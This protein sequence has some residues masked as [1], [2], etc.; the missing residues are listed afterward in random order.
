[1][2]CVSV[3]LWIVAAQVV[4][5]LQLLFWQSARWLLLG[6]ICLLN[7]HQCLT[8]RIQILRS[9]SSFLK[10][11]FKL[12]IFNLLVLDWALLGFKILCFT[13]WNAFTIWIFFSGTNKHL[14]S[15]QQLLLLFVLG[16]HLFVLAFRLA[17]FL[18]DLRKLH[19]HHCLLRLGLSRHWLFLWIV[20][21]SVALQALR[22]FFRRALL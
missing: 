17:L 2:D 1:M 22:L 9:R 20:V 12:S 14:F 5:T 21:D 16:S 15:L 4:F 3:F 10:L 13:V 11:V 18:S 6:W 7:V 8:S 19:L